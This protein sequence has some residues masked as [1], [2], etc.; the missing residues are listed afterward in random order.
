MMDFAPIRHLG[1]P[2]GPVAYRRAGSG[3][4]LLLIHGWR[5][6]S[7]YWQTTAHAFADIRDVHALD[8]P[9]HG[10]T[11]PREAPIDIESLAHLSMNLADGLG[12]ERMDL[13]GHSFGGAVA[14]YMAAHWPERVRRLAI[15][16][17]GTVRNALE[18]FALSQAHS[19]FNQGLHFARPWLNLGRPWIGALQPWIDR[20][21]S[22][23]GIAR[24][25]AGAFVSRLPQDEALVREG[26]MEFLR[27]DPLSSLEIAVAS[28]SPRFIEALARVQ[29]PTLLLCGDCDRIMPLSAARAMAERLP[30]ARLETLADCGHLPMIE[31]PETLH[32][33]MRD[34]FDAAD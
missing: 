11:P 22:D 31:Q 7:R 1:L 24:T 23:P 8:L 18:Q 28:G 27:T 14:A 26:V 30:N 33:L 21:G 3:V 16:S 25:I 13:A 15:A 2:C 29:A 20:V 34:F 10:E 5:G 19:H 32:R 9:G 17:M 6:S 12:L 4:P